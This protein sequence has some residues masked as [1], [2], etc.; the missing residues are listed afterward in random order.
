M[1]NV[2]QIRLVSALDNAERSATSAASSPESAI[3]ATARSSTHAAWRERASRPTE[4]QIA[5]ANSGES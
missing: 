2:S 5:I 1:P 4:R 3:R